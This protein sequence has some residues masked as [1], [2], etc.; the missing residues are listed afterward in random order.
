MDRAEFLELIE[1]ILYQEGHQSKQGRIIK[2]S[3][4]A[5]R[6]DINVI[7]KALGIEKL[8]YEETEKLGY[9]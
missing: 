9:G 7:A 6:Q 3:V 5:Q 8:I 1:G 2:A 4:R